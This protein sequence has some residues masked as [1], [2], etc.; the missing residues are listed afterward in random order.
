MNSGRRFFCATVARIDDEET[1]TNVKFNRPARVLYLFHPRAFIILSCL[2][3]STNLPPATA[4]VFHFRHSL[5]LR[6]YASH[7]FTS[8]SL[9]LLSP[10]APRLQRRRRR[11]VVVA[12]RATPPTIVISDRL[13]VCGRVLSSPTTNEDATNAHATTHQEDEYSSSRRND[14]SHVRVE[15]ECRY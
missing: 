12:L 7:P 4:A 11:S 15:P 14:H 1:S 13:L 10:T 5:L 6:L 2:P 3:P 9:S 8:S